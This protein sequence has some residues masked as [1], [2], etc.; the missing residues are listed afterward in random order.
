MLKISKEMMKD[1]HL[2]I[3]KHLD[4][5]PLVF[6]RWLSEKYGCEVWLK[7]ENM[8]PIGSFKIRGATNKIA[9]LTKAEKVNGVLAVSAGNHAQ[10][11]AWA[12]KV[13][14][15]KA[16]IIMPINAP[17]TKVESTK[18]LGAKVILHGN[19]VEDSFKYANEL[20]K[21]T[22]A[23]FVHPFEDQKVISGQ[24]TCALEI[25]ESLKDFDYL[26]GSI[27]GGGFI[28]GMGLA[29]KSHC[30]KAK[31]VGAQ[32]LG[33]N[34]M[35]ESIRKKKVISH[36][37]SDTFA[38]GIKVKSASSSMY[39]LLKDVVDEVYDIPDEQIA[40]AVLEL[41]EKAR[42]VAE[43][44]GALPLAVLQHIHQKNPQSLKNKKV[45]LVIGGGNIDVNLLGHIIGRGLSVSGRHL[46]LNIFVSDRPGTLN[47]LTTVIAD[48]GGNILQVIHDHE[49][50]KCALNEAVIELT[51]ETKGE[52]HSLEIIKA[53]KKHFPKMV[54][55]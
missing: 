24:A 27:G 22:G 36:D 39:Q 14:K 25:M 29:L 41:V 17:I 19:N 2:L 26:I 13:F 32:A 5:T 34:A 30:H 49:H 21:K 28:A 51:L 50:P 15:T 35:V 47:L 6:N 8:Q 18:A 45:V 31:V 40:F 37:T 33:A 44:A 46:R 3:K 20:I 11:V 54:R 48:H 53:L 10:G 38:D 23:V 4:P 1:A 42:V 12:A 55:S 16:T 7:L 43:G 9:G 52:E